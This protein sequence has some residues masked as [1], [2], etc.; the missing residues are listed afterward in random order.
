MQ[1]RQK[2]T[3]YSKLATFE[4]IQPSSNFVPTPPRQSKPSVQSQ[5]Q[6]DHPQS[7]CAHPVYPATNFTL[8]VVA[9]VVVTV[10]V[11]VCSMVTVSCTVTVTGPSEDDEEATKP[12]PG[13]P[14]LLPESP[15]PPPSPWPP[16][17]PLPGLSLTC[18][19][20]PSAPVASPRPG[21]VVVAAPPPPMGLTTSEDGTGKLKLSCRLVGRGAAGVVE[22]TLGG[23]GSTSVVAVVVVGG[24]AASGVLVGDGSVIVTKVVTVPAGLELEDGLGT[25][26]VTWDLGTVS[27][28]V[29]VRSSVLD[30]RDAATEVARGGGEDAWKVVAA[31]PPLL[32]RPAVCVKEKFGEFEFAL[33]DVWLPWPSP[34]SAPVALFRILSACIV[35]KHPTVAPLE[36]ATGRAKQPSP[37]THCVRTT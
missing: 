23:D 28:L 25:V 35:S 18:G 12:L 20:G 21:T 3:S 6:P 27:V 13:R 19:P 14:P 32:P 33:E 9:A 15:L 30:V 26:I 10:C 2:R 7:T 22:V 31:L 16:P 17:P 29:V 36:F 24:A 34:P 1:A 4:M 37:C 8:V 5:S 11:C